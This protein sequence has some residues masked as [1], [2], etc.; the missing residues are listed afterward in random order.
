MIEQKPSSIEEA[1]SLEDI[2]SS[3]ERVGRVDFSSQLGADE[4]E[5][6]HNEVSSL[7]SMAR[8]TRPVGQDGE[9]VDVSM[10]LILPPAKVDEAMAAEAAATRRAIAEARGEVTDEEELDELDQ[11]EDLIEDLD[12]E[13]Q[14]DEDEL[15]LEPVEASLEVEIA[16]VIPEPEP[17]PMPE[18]APARRER[19][20][21][22]KAAPEPEAP[23]PSGSTG[24][25]L[26][27]QD[28]A[29]LT[30]IAADA[31]AQ[32]AAE[33]AAAAEAEAEAAESRHEAEVA[34]AAEARTLARVGA[35]A[36][37]GRFAPVED[38]DDLLDDDFDDDEFDLEPPA[39]AFSAPAGQPVDAAVAEVAASVIALM[40]STE[41]AHQRHLEAVELEAARRCELLTAQAE[42]DAELIRLN[43]RREAHAIISAART[44]SGESPAPVE[45]DHQLSE[46]GETFSRFAET[47]ETTMASGLESP[48][49]TRKS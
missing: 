8:P 43:A 38:L 30:Q 7:T 24:E 5:P 17:E 20:R 41:D 25:G 2:T 32:A 44:R 31:A 40:R 14:D 12:D 45:S 19:R 37:L 35:A 29:S 26:M 15:D 33:E 28:V 22:R 34:A 42:L 49:Q 27:I 48:D 11:D 4:P 10:P 3:E 21:K 23:V 18:P 1:P 46:I 16:E 6:E 36:D 39:P 47:I 9:D 13:L